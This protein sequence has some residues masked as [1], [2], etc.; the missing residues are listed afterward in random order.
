MQTKMMLCAVFTNLWLVYRSVR[1]AI[2]RIFFNKK[3]EDINAVGVVF[4]ILNKPLL[5]IKSLSITQAFYLSP[6]KAI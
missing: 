4:F 3:L 1:S 6:Y 5:K 2:E